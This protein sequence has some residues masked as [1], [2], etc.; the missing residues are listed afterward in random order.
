MKLGLFCFYILHPTPPAP[1]IARKDVSAYRR[2]LHVS[3]T[4]STSSGPLIPHETTDCTDYTDFTDCADCADFCDG[5]IFL[6]DIGNLQYCRSLAE[7]QSI[8]E[9][10][11]LHVSRVSARILNI[12]NTLS[13]LR[14]LNPP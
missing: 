2:Y 4:S 7:A 5:K 6:Y 3:L 9:E 12:L 13:F 14:S 11:C 1:R 10:R 8:A